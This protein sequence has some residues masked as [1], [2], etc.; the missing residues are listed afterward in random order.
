ML[1][2]ARVGGSRAT[3]WE[4]RPTRG[5]DMK[6]FALWWNIGV[7]TSVA[8]GIQMLKR[9]MAS[10]VFLVLVVYRKWA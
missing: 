9:R 5:P 1:V 10:F 3:R 6:G 2:S 8:L 4:S 7:C